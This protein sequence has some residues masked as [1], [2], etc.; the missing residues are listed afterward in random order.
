MEN[1]TGSRDACESLWSVR[2]VKGGEVSKGL[3]S[4]LPISLLI[5]GKGGS[6]RPERS[7]G[8]AQIFIKMKRKINKK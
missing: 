7:E 2:D 1:R 5:R 3:L 4:N 6:A 8:H